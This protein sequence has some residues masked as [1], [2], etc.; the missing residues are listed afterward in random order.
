M[1]HIRVVHFFGML[2]RKVNKRNI[3][4]Y[5]H[6]KKSF[7]GLLDLGTQIRCPQNRYDLKYPVQSELENEKAK[8]MVLL[9][10][11]SICWT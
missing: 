4:V 1:F 2:K 5:F 11:D 7:P 6:K 9:Y 10:M 3:Y 8:I